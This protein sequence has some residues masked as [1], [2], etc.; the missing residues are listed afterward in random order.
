MAQMELIPRQPPFL[1]KSQHPR[2]Y[3]K[4]LTQEELNERLSEAKYHHALA[5]DTIAASVTVCPTSAKT[6]ARKRKRNWGKKIVR[7]KE[8][9]ERRKE[10]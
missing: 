4:N 10:L 2:K 7:I 5:R 3:L 1:A 8:E 9:L 6:L